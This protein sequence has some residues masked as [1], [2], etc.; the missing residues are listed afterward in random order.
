MRLRCRREYPSLG[1]QPL[2]GNSARYTQD[3][4]LWYPIY[5]R[6][7]QTL[8]A[9]QLLQK[10]CGAR[11]NVTNSRFHHRQLTILSLRIYDFNFMNS[12]IYYFN[13]SFSRFQHSG[14]TISTKWIHDF[15]EMNLTW[16]IHD[17]STSW[18]HDFIFMN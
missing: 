8:K 17:S 5:D 1:Y 6:C 13:F 15:N 18:I 14:F 12:L 2:G 9:Y 7:K 3:G 4:N 16:W 10:T 11:L